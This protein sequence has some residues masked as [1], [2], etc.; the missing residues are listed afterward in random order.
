M[1]QKRLEPYKEQDLLATQAGFRKSRGTR[2]HIAN[3]RRV[4]RL[5][6]KIRRGYVSVLLTIA[7]R[8]NAYIMTCFGMCY[9]G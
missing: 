6:E 9:D 5:Q 2:D 3:L 4:W 8:S 1:I 7:R